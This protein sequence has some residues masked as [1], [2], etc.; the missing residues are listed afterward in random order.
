MKGG[1]WRFQVYRNSLR[2]VCTVALRAK[3]ISWRSGPRVVCISQLTHVFVHKVQQGKNELSRCSRAYCR[4]RID[5]IWVLTPSFQNCALAQT[6]LGMIWPVT[7]EFGLSK[8]NSE[9]HHNYPRKSRTR[10]PIACQDWSMEK[11]KWF[12]LCHPVWIQIFLSYT[13]RRDMFSDNKCLSLSG[14]EFNAIYSPVIVLNLVTISSWTTPIENNVNSHTLSGWRAQVPWPGWRP[15]PVAPVGFRTHQHRTRHWILHQWGLHR[16]TAESH[17]SA[18]SGVCLRT[19]CYW[20]IKT[21]VQCRS[22]AGHHGNRS[23][24]LAEIFF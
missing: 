4:T 9:I 18:H 14:H 7:R 6:A 22:G 11:Y 17:W 23:H 3:G 16:N 15:V 24:F 20:P 12:T 5:Q 13:R 2:Y 21:Y 10:S 8:Q 1:D 19:N